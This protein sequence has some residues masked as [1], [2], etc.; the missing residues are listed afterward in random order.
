VIIDIEPDDLDQE[1]R[2]AAAPLRA[3]REEDTVLP[4]LDKR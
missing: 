1:R 4:S 2:R 3:F